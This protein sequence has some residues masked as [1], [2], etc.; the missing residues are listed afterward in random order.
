MGCGCAEGRCWFGEY[1]YGECG[2]ADVWQAVHKNGQVK[3]HFEMEGG[4]VEEGGKAALERRMEEGEKVG[5]RRTER[6]SRQSRN[7]LIYL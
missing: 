6:S 3:Q 1:Y 7:L 4:E 2:N 5:E